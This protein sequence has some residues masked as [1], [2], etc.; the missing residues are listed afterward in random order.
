MKPSTQDYINAQ[1]NAHDTYFTVRIEGILYGVWLD[2]PSQWGSFDMIDRW[3]WEVVP[4]KSININTPMS[5]TAHAKINSLID[6]LN[7]TP[8]YAGLTPQQFVA[9]VLKGM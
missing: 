3:W 6:L 7:K 8:G 9:M 1:K 4:E 5:A 2:M